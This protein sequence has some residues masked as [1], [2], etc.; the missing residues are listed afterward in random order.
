MHVHEAAAADGINGAPR[1][2]VTGEIDP[3]AVG[4]EFRGAGIVSRRAMFIAPP[5]QA[6]TNRFLIMYVSS[7]SASEIVTSKNPP[8]SAIYT[9]RF[10]LPISTD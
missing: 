2:A 9:R 10:I 5:L 1:G 7:C 4:Y 6:V 8:L 3:F